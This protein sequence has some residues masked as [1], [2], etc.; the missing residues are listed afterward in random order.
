MVEFIDDEKHRLT[1]RRSRTSPDGAPKLVLTSEPIFCFV[2][3]CVWG[4]GELRG[5]MEECGRKKNRKNLEEAVRMARGNT[6]EGNE[7]ESFEGWMGEEVQRTCRETI[8]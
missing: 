3:R 2:T 5:Q 1:W 6:D 7:G 8:F 4:G